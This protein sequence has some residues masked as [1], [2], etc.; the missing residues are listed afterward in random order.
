MHTRSSEA[1]RINGVLVA[2]RL[3][4]DRQGRALPAW[5]T[6]QRLVVDERL[7]SSTNQKSFDSRDLGPLP[8]GAVTIR[9]QLLWS[10]LCR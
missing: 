9:A 6:C 8:V 3:R 7:L 10:D 2:R 1:I 5:Q 4:R